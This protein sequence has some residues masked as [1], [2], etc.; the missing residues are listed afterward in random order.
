MSVGIVGVAE[1]I[2]ERVED[3]VQVLECRR[4]EPDI[5]LPRWIGHGQ[6]RGYDVDSVVRYEAGVFARGAEP[7]DGTLG[8][9]CYSRGGGDWRETP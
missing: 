3:L 4:V 6:D 1:V 7:I 2:E 5:P 9:R 8:M